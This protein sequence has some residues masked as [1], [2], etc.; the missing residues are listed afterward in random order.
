M[1]L[2][3]IPMKKGHS[4]FV[5]GGAIVAIAL[6]SVVVLAQWSSEKEV[7]PVPDRNAAPSHQNLEDRRPSPPTNFRVE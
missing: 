6:N 3:E 4:V 1:R 2:K 7:G 5:Y